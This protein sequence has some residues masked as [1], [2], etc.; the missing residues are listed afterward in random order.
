MYP[1]I[2][3]GDHVKV[4]LCVDGELIE[5]GDIIVYC[6]LAAGGLGV[7]YGGMWIGHRVIQKFRLDGK[8]CFKTQGD[9][10]SK[11]DPWIVK[12]HFLL[13]KVVGVYHVG[14][15]TPTVQETETIYQLTSFEDQILGLGWTGIIGFGFI[16]VSVL[17]RRRAMKVE[18]LRRSLVLSCQ[19]CTH[20]QVY[21]TYRL[22]NENGRFGIKTQVHLPRGI[23]KKTNKE[24]IN[25][26]RKPICENY[27]KKPHI[28]HKNAFS[29]YLGKA[30]NV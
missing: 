11:S 30:N 26:Y 22:Y 2:R 8:W 17:V 21:K 24:V 13:G 6:S 18:M 14:S 27:T 16:V 4:K 12:E 5:V 3:D 25:C 7:N 19:N 1:A 23:C 10:C 28:N 20:F 15:S 29:N 9:N